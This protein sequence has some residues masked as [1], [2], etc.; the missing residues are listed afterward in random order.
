MKSLEER[1]GEA[2]HYRLEWTTCRVCGIRSRNKT[3]RAKEMMYRTG[4]E[5]DYFICNHC[6]CMQISKIPED[7]GK[8]YA[9][10]YYSMEKNG[11]EYLFQDQGNTEIRVLDVGCG[12]GAWLL[13][14]AKSGCG[15]LFGCDPFIEEDIHYGVRVH[16]KKCE[17][18][19]MKGTFDIIRFGD[20][21]EHIDRPLETLK[22]VKR[23]LSV[24]GTCQIRMPVFPNAAWDIFGIYWYQLDAPR[25]IFLHSEE[26]MQFLCKQCGLKIVESVYNANE[27]QFLYSYLYM[28]GYSYEEAINQAG[29]IRSENEALFENFKKDSMKCNEKRYGDHVVFHIVH[30]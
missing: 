9:N 17:I 23:I 3:Y 6:K 11:E 13:K 5:F 12:T 1:M 18:T 24:D 15:N 28:D 26:S 22:A 16:I 4:E 21:F 29:I 7:L 20:S 25:H 19:D 14:W 27:M 2:H 30:V 10:D 8:Y